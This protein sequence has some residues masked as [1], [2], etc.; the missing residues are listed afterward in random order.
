MNIDDFV[1]RHDATMSSGMSATSTSFAHLLKRQPYV[2]TMTVCAKTSFRAPSLDALQ[3]ALGSAFVEAKRFRNCIIIKQPKEST[4]YG[5]NVTT[6]VFING[7]FHMTGPTSM[8]VAQEAADDILLAL[9]MMLKIGGIVTH[10]EIT[11]I[12]TSF[13]TT[14]QVG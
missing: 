1:S 10:M 5:C 8:R 4:S 11:M 2:A 13:V 9:Y 6:K 12:N 14:R 3:T 7:V